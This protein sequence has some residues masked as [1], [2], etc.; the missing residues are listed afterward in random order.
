MS[1]KQNSEVSEDLMWN[2]GVRKLVT[3]LAEKIL[4][5]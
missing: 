1:L 3:Y 4:G 5:K 2:K